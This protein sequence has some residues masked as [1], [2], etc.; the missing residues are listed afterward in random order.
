M[1]FRVMQLTISRQ[2]PRAVAAC[3]NFFWGV[4]KFQCMLL[5][6]ISYPIDF[7]F[8]FNAIKFGSLLMNW[9][10]REKIFTYFCNKFR[11]VNHM[12]DIKYDVNGSLHIF[13]CCRRSVAPWITVLSWH[14]LFTTRLI[15]YKFTFVWYSTKQGTMHISTSHLA[16][17]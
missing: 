5:E 16:H 15:H 8:I 11:L 3:R 9:F 2:M 1:K 17:I 4:F 6:K 14:T 10:I 13:G 12:H 7:S